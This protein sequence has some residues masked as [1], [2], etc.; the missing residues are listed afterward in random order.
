MAELRS[1][2]S[3][4]E[5]RALARLLADAP[6]MPAS[7]IVQM[8][9][10]PQTLADWARA[11]GI[12]SAVA[13]NML[14]R[15]K[16]Y[17]R[18]RELLAA[19]LEVPA[20]VLDHLVDAGRPLPAARSTTPRSLTLPDAAPP[21][22]VSPTERL[23]AVRDGSNPLEQRALWRVR[24]EIA[25]LPASLVVQLAIFPETLA[26]WARR[27]S[28]P[29]AMVYTTLAGSQRNPRIRDQLARRLD[30]GSRD[31]DQLID[32]VRPEATSLA[33]PVAP[34]D[35]AL[36]SRPFAGADSAPPRS[37]RDDDY[38]GPRH[39]EHGSGAG[40]DDASDQRQLDLGL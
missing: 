40:S 24:N 5:Q 37:N 13:Y 35:L 38:P 4:I 15:F 20:W 7:D 27:K 25:A 33:P 34:G 16:P 12:A 29:A 31:V 30:V 26:E 10:W 6:A 23:P 39:D 1:G 14:A 2:N 22:D 18:V 8:L 32:S 11:N 21:R 9:L 28:V 3:P 17:R 19:R 36:P